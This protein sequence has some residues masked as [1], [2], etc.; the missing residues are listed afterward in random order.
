MREGCPV[1][2]VRVILIFYPE[3]ELVGVAEDGG[4][5]CSLEYLAMAMPIRYDQ[6]NPPYMQAWEMRLEPQISILN[7]S[8]R[9]CRQHNVG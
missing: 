2:V 8:V 6:Y 7:N 3:S 5:T 9:H 1:V 4:G